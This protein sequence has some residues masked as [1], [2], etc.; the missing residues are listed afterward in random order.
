MTRLSL[1]VVYLWRHVSSTAPPFILWWSILE[2]L[3]S[4][5]HR[6]YPFICELP[7][8]AIQMEQGPYIAE[9]NPKAIYIVRC[10]WDSS[11]HC[12]TRQMPFE[13]F[14]RQDS[15][16]K[17]FEATDISTYQSVYVHTESNTT[18][19]VKEFKWMTITYTVCR[20]LNS[21]K[22]IKWKE[23]RHMK[24]IGSAMS[25]YLYSLQRTG[26]NILPIPIVLAFCRA[27]RTQSA[28]F[29]LL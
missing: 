3:F 12:K 22:K 26:F 5:F 17:C 27:W 23:L 20:K 10:L 13:G 6:S 2:I 21:L 7:C 28:M 18:S 16:S 9:R 15:K 8:Q 1:L 24:M 29:F 4:P 11:N 25:A 14:S 19:V